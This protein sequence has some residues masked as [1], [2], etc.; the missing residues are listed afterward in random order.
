MANTEGPV[1]GTGGRLTDEEA[2]SLAHRIGIYDT[3]SACLQEKILEALYDEGVLV[4]DSNTGEIT[5]ITEGHEWA[6][7][8]HDLY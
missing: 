3:E 4:Q 1:T 8:N 7:C 2:S 6:A 5:G